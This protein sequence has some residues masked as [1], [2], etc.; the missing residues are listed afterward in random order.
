MAGR[1]RHRRGGLDELVARFG[2][3]DRSN[4]GS[5][6]VGVV[7]PTRATEAER[8]VVCQEVFFHCPRSD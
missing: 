2:R 3:I 8:V 6:C 1:H 4:L 5:I 7:G